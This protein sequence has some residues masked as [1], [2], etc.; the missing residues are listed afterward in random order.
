MPF[1]SQIYLSTISIE[2]YR[3]LIDTHTP[4]GYHPDTRDE[5]HI[6]DI[7]RYPG[8]YMLGVQGAGK[9]RLLQNLIAADMH[10]GNPVIV[11]D[12]HGDLTLACL[13]D[14]P[15]ERIPHMFLLDMEDE[16]YPYGVNLFPTS[17]PKTS[18]ER[19]QAVEQIM[20]IFEVLWPEVVNQ[21]YIPLFLPNAI[22]VF[23]DNPGKTLKDMLKFFRDDTFRAAMLRNVTDPSLRDFW[24]YEYDTR[25][26]TERRT[27]VRPLTDRLHILFTGN[28]L[29]SN[30]FGQPRTTI[31]FRKAIEARQI[32][33]IKLPVT[34]PHIS[35]LIGT[36]LLAQI[37][38]AVFSFGDIPE[39]KRPG[40]SLYMDEFQNF[41]TKDIEKLFTQGRK[42]G[43][44]LT[45][46]HQ[47]RNQLP[48]FLQASTMTART[49]ICFQLTPEDG[50][51]MAHVFPAAET[52]IRPEDMAEHPS[53]ELLAHTPEVEGVEAFVEL[54]LRPLQGHKRGAGRVEI[55]MR[56]SAPSLFEVMQGGRS[57]NP[58]VADP[59]PY[60]DSLLHKVM[61]TGDPDL[62]IPPEVVRGFANCGGG[63]FK[64]ARRLHY[65]SKQL[66]M[67]V[68][69]PSDLIILK[70]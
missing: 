12:P 26:D 8:T 24:A 31:D 69:Y 13:N 1:Y 37:Q 62:D 27:R 10:A 46:A 3:S 65:G 28:N 57:D 20:H 67:Q 22:L 30:I 32:I 17:K 70:I 53:R 35:R 43:M 64:A 56:N 68:D 34:V 66:T 50:H 29:L 61:V 36:I 44:R 52:T 48:T 54:Y 45:V 15:P 38:T 2:K 18:I 9:S 25:S 40:V 59:T 49:K 42:F 23:L 58:K 19:T 51:E 14:V 33:I 39:S 7:D 5:F 55:E 6:P 41:A 11:I 60:L 21:A 63:F 4:I 16:G 47:Q